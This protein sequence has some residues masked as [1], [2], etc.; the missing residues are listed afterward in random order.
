MRNKSARLAVLHDITSLGRTAR[1]T[2]GPVQAPS[3]LSHYYA[4]KTN[5]LYRR[6]RILFRLYTVIV[7]TQQS[8]VLISNAQFSFHENDT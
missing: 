5:R 1:S 7:C 6:P 4:R 3:D 8:Q 2:Q